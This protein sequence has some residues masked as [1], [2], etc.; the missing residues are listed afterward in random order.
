VGF[1]DVSALLSAINAKCGL[2]TFHGPTVTALARAS[3]TARNKFYSALTSETALQ[4]KPKSGTVLCSGTVSGKVT[5]G[6]LTTLCH[7]VGTPFQPDF[8]GR[9]LFLEDTGEAAYRI[10][11][12]M[13]QMKLAGCFN[14]IAGLVLGSF[15]RCG[16]IDEIFRIVEEIFKAPK[17]PILAGMPSGH[18]RSN[19]IIPFGMTA[20]LDTGR[21]R[22]S[23]HEP[24][25]AQTVDI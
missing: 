1:S 9:I 22:L 10:D 24:A 12:M 14:G 7:L 5:G 3:K 16:T 13:T 17:I 25:T 23:F 20:T 11:R 15:R 21:K 8:N 2:V 18:E 4:M 6:N 19:H